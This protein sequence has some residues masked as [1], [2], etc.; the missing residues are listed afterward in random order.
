MTTSRLRHA[1]STV[2]VAAAGLLVVFSSSNCASYQRE[3]ARRGQVLD[4][5]YVRSM[6]FER[7][8]ST[9]AEQAA[10]FRAD[11]LTETDALQGRVDQLEAQ[12]IDVLDRLDRISRRVGA[13]RADMTPV[14]SDSAQPADTARAPVD[15]AGMAEDQLYGTAYLDFTRGKYDVAIAEFRRYLESFPSSDNADNAQYWV[16]ECFYSLAR[17]DSAEVEFKQVVTRYPTGNKLP[18]AEYKLGLVYLGTSR[19]AAARS[20]FERVLREYPGTNEAK[21]AQDRLNSLE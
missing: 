5:L 19:P 12:L 15:T 18:A 10:R 7:A 4:S 13:G 8:E 17:L 3:Y 14:K 6:R 20:Q 21:L 11:V 1:T 9:Q 16:G 2:L